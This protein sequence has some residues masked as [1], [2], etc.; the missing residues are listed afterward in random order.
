MKDVTAMR[1]PCTATSESPPLAATREKPAQH[2]RPSTAPDK[3]IKRDSYQKLYAEKMYSLG[4]TDKF[5]DRY[6][7]PRLKREKIENTNKS[8]TSIKTESVS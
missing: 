2:Q 6:N 3:R 5:L 7:F 8:M 4:K 1:S